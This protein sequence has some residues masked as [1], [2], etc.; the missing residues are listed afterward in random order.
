MMTKKQEII[1]T[2]DPWTVLQHPSMTEKSIRYIE[3][4]NKLVFIVNR[5]ATKDTIKRAIETAFG[6]KVENVKTLL[7]TDNHKKAYVKLAKGNNAS[8]VATRLGII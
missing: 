1:S 3:S 8:D 5:K 7:A 6:V 4:E 2:W